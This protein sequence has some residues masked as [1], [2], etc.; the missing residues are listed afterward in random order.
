MTE[1]ICGFLLIKRDKIIRISALQII[2][3]LSNKIIHTNIQNFLF[4]FSIKFEFWKSLLILEESIS[5]LSLKCDII[6]LINTSL[7]THGYDA[8]YNFSFDDN[9]LIWLKKQLSTKDINF[10]H[11]TLL[12]IGNFINYDESKLLG[13]FIEFYSLKERIE[14]IFYMTQNEIILKQCSSILTKISREYSL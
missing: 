1:N 8:F 4:L 14:I 3:S 12:E 10:L 2:L 7:I 9:I 13:E 11:I 5:N 6:S